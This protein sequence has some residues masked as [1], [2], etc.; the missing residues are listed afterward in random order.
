MVNDMAAMVVFRM[1]NKLWSLSTFPPHM[2]PFIQRYKVITISKNMSVVELVKG[3]DS[4]L[5]FKWFATSCKA[6]I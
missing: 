5:D 3:C 6:N 1:F 4:T 2:H